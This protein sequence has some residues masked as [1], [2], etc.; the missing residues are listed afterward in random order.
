MKR[1]LIILPVL[2]A[3][4]CETYTMEKTEHAATQTDQHSEQS[5]ANNPL[6]LFFLQYEDE[7][8]LSIL[9]F[10][11]NIENPHNRIRDLYSKK[12]FPRDGTRR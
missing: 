8:S 3:I 9:S 5:A 11:A 1:A 4:V 7:V 2:L 10:L 6:L 12:T